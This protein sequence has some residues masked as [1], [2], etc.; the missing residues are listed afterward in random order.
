MFHVSLAGLRV[1][2]G[3]E[4]AGLGLGLGLGLVTAGLQQTS[5]HGHCARPH[6]VTSLTMLD[7]YPPP[8]VVRR[9]VV[10]TS[11]VD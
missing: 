5:D 3:L 11:G 10:A 7:R 8:D 1:G 2:L 6:P 9:V 4:T